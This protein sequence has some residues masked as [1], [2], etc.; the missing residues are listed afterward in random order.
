[1]THSRDGDCLR[2]GCKAR[3]V[4]QENLAVAL[5]KRKAVSELLPF[6]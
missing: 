4:A 5:C 2:T 6:L 1:M 3:S